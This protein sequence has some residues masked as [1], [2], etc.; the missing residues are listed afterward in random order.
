MILRLD[1]R[2]RRCRL[3]QVQRSQNVFYFLHGARIIGLRRGRR[4]AAE[5][6]GHEVARLRGCGKYGQG[7]AKREQ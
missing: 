4:V 7:A 6:H 3:V 5:L 2:H 1:A